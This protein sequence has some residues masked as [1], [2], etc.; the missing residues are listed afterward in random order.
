MFKKAFSYCKQF[1][2]HRHKFILVQEIK[3]NRYLF[4]S[5]NK[6]IKHYL[7][8]K[9]SNPDKDLEK[10]SELFEICEQALKKWNKYLF[11]YVNKIELGK[12]GELDIHEKNKNDEIL[13]SG[14]EALEPW[15]KT[16]I[17]SAPDK[18]FNFE[19]EEASGANYTNFDIESS[20]SDECTNINPKTVERLNSK[21]FNCLFV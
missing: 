18:K 3:I 20:F 2:C 11:L 16:K 19:K 7:F 14:E 1:I 12:V 10:A 9:T 4:S 8:R 15:N 17:R 21:V 6:L 5:C 13:S